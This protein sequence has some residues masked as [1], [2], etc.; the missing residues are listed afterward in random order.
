MLVRR[1]ETA[2]PRRGGERSALALPAYLQAC[3]LLLVGESP[4]HGYDLRQGLAGL[5]VHTNDTGRVYRALREMERD[6]LVASW[7]DEAPRGPARRVYHLTPKGDEQLHASA[8]LVNE[9]CF[10]LFGYLHRWKRL[11]RPEGEGARPRL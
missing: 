3:L 4:G 6:G 1:V 7:W 2:R 8:A 11:A 5:G 10:Q 9:T